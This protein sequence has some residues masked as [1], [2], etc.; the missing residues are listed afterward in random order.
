MT[1][2]AERAV[3][4][5]A[6]EETLPDFADIFDG[7]SWEARLAQA[8]AKREKALAGRQDSPLK[9]DQASHKSPGG[10]AGTA[11]RPADRREKLAK[12]SKLSLD[13]VLQTKNLKER[14]ELAQ[15]RH[16]QVASTQDSHPQA[17]VPGLAGD[18][19]ADFKKAV[20]RAKPA[21]MA[22]E[23]KA[24]TAQAEP[25]EPVETSARVL[26]LILPAAVSAEPDT[27]PKHWRLAAALVLIGLG[28]GGLAALTLSQGEPTQ[29]ANLAPDVSDVLIPPGSA[30]LPWGAGAGASDAAIPGSGDVT[31]AAGLGFADPDIVQSGIDP[32]RTQAATP[33]QMI[34]AMSA[35]LGQ[36]TPDSLGFQPA[37]L[38]NPVSVEPALNIDIANAVP[39]TRQSVGLQVPFRPQGTPAGPDTPVAQIPTAPRAQTPFQVSGDIIG[40]FSITP[41]DQSVSFAMNRAT[42]PGE[43]ILDRVAPR[44]I[45]TLSRG[46]VLAGIPT[47]ALPIAVSALAPA[48]M[49]L[50]ALSAPSD[51][52]QSAVMQ[53][54]S[55][56]SPVVSEPPRLTGHGHHGTVPS[57]GAP[58][59]AVM[60][61]PAHRI[62][63]Y[64]PSAVPQEQSDQVLGQLETAGFSV[65]RFKSVGFTVSA[66]N[67]RYYH[68]ADA[69]TA[70]ALADLVQ[71]KARDFTDFS[72]RPPLGTVELWLAGDTPK[73]QP[74]RRVARRV[75]RS[76]DS[77]AA[78]RALRD[79][80]VQQLR[81]GEHLGGGG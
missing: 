42:L 77:D 34:A 15:K 30:G 52:G 60:A 4:G 67:V 55:L 29:V 61:L 14:L 76:S 43:P 10:E 19:R 71:A 46:Q 21:P 62:Q 66:N 75:V 70:R 35:P 32:D 44:G 57:F 27:A 25:Q 40:D 7:D 79:R 6:L 74:R 78:L 80:L 58:P 41:L 65:G 45:A 20:L 24:A 81:Q 59:S 3:A 47:M 73:A 26:P 13:D 9:P 18:I 68:A 16:A 64:A 1:A 38:Q 22:A 12:D 31:L 5:P 72:P 28:A 63:V 48:P 33:D 17:G 2:K 39:A 37:D 54:S 50:A 8:R 53:L 51:P 23:A 56:W 49:E 36:G 69:A 11:A